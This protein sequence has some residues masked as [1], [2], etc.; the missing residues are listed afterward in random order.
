MAQTINIANIK[1]GLNAEGG[2]FT[3]G[4]IRSISRVLRESEA[5]ASKF[6]AEMDK[7]QRALRAGGITMEQ[8]VQSEEH[9]LKKFGMV[10]TA[11]GYQTAETV[12]L[13][14]ASKQATTGINQA[15]TAI[16]N[17]TSAV[18]SLRG[19]MA[20]YIGTAAAIGGIKKS[21]SLAAELETNKIAFE[22]MT[23][24]ASRAETM[25]RQFK[26]L[27][28]QSPINYADF[29]TAGKT[30][31]QFGMQAQ[32]V[33]LTLERLS[34][35][36]LG[37]TEQFKSLALAFGQV[38][39]NGRLMGQE[40]LQFIN[41]GFNPLQEIS[42]TT[43]IS[44]AE[45]K[46]RMEDGAISAQ[47]VAN[48]FKTAT[49][50]GGL[51]YGMNQRLAESMA[52]QWAKLEGDIKAAAIS[53]G[54]DL[55]PLMKQAVEMIRG[56]GQTNGDRG[57]LGFNIKLISDSYASL[58]A[59]IQTGLQSAGRSVRNMDLTTG[60]VSALGD[61]FNATLDKQQEI[62]DAELD[63]EAALMRAADAEG[64]IT[65]KKQ[66]TLAQAKALAEEENKRVQSEK[67]RVERLKQQIELNKKTGD[68]LWAMREKLDRLTMGEDAAR[69]QKQAREGYTKEDITRFDNMQKLIDAE[70]Q[71]IKMLQE[72]QAIEKEMMSDKQKAV[73]EIQRLQGIY[74]QMSLAEQTGTMGQA[75]LAKQEQI[76]Q[77][78]AASQTTEDIAKNIAPAMRAG[79]KE[80]ASFLLQ[81]RTDAAEKA[82][83]KKWQDSLLA[84]TRRGNELAVNA[85]RLARAR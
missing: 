28:V 35:V 25:L 70:E 1:I 62:K 76:R 58:F 68:E 21:I 63:R 23:G 52:G 59:G 69:R 19:M 36:S 7:M 64:D 27:D 4:E 77:R 43:G 46:K 31:L 54:T 41:A 60:L 81:Q 74:D 18:Q 47:M 71:R 12:K 9:L 55:M 39:A 72:S 2:E 67:D 29:A 80:A 30:L 5:P 13:A 73:E 38:T 15:T 56:D 65:S 24:S 79:S 32:S 22:V 57:V 16:S 48:A 66:E 61:A 78:F 85:P 50:E 20:G 42:R 6:S 40:V 26:A 49:E 84:E 44:M 17:Q 37:N 51:F 83:R 10:A 14:N 45:L 3:R 34:A 8:F 33:P 53:L 82:E 11:T 75:N